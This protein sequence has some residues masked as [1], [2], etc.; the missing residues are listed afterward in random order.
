MGRGDGGRGIEGE[1]GAGYT[2]CVGTW[3][4]QLE[5]RAAGCASAEARCNNGPGGM[6]GMH[7][8]GGDSSGALGFGVRGS[9]F[10]VRGSGFGMGGWGFG[11][12]VSGFG[13]GL[14]VS[15]LRGRTVRYPVVVETRAVVVDE[16]LVV[17]VL[18]FPIGDPSPN[19]RENGATYLHTAC[20]KI[21]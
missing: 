8:C 4:Q 6:G 10:G 11:F 12:R 19:V 16:K 18:D 20:R 3:Q 14:R 15:G 7:C 9:G 17:R 21:A 2:A 5:G 1:T 13:M